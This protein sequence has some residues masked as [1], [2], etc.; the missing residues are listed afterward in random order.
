MS[1]D[2]FSE[3]VLQEK[4]HGNY[5]VVNKYSDAGLQT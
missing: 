4:L 5:T 3:R 2:F 1:S